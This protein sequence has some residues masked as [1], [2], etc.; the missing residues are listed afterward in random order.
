MTKEYTQQSLTKMRRSD[1]QIRRRVRQ[2]IAARDVQIDIKAC[3]RD[4][5]ACLKYGEDHREAATIPAQNRS[6]WLTVG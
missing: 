1:R 3:K 4:A 5:A 2:A 6:P